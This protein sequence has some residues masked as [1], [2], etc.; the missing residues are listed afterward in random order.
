MKFS[1]ILL[2]ITLFTC[3][4]SFV[5]A[6]ELPTAADVQAPYLEHAID[7]ITDIYDR[8]PEAESSINWEKFQLADEDLGV[9]Y[10]LLTSEADKAQFRCNYTHDL[11]EY[12]LTEGD[13]DG[14]FDWQISDK[15]NNVY[16]VQ[17]LTLEFEA[18][19]I[20]ELV[21]TKRILIEEY[22]DFY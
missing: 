1:A 13:M 19:F 15:G 14:F 18:V 8:K 3:S 11:A 4:F 7:I 10:Q 20:F 16:Q 21:D 9:R 5:K 2:L 17:A 6:Q 22:S 12:L